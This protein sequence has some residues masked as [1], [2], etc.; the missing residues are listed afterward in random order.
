[1]KKILLLLT[2][3]IAI[4]VG[5]QKK[6]NFY[7][8]RWQP[9]ESIGR[10]RYLSII[11]KNDSLWKRTDYFIKENK[12]QMVGTYKDSETKTEHGP[13]EYF[14]ANGI[15]QSKGSYADGKKE[16]MWLR[17]YNNGAIQDS[18]VYTNGEIKGIGLAWHRNGFLADSSTYNA[19]GSGISVQWHDNGNPSAA[20]MYTAARKQHGKW[21][22]FHKNGNLSCIEIY[23]SGQFVSK[24]YYFEDGTEMKDTASKDKE[25]SFPGGQKAWLRYLERNLYFPSQWKINGSDEIVVTVDW[26]IDEEG[27]IQ[28]VFV[29]SPF[30]PDFDKIAADV[31]RKSPKWLPALSHNRTIKAYR[32][33]PVT[34]AQL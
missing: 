16:G 5:A 21:Q 23:H 15:P 28:D 32:R 8:F 24:K 10:A 11:N 9:T 26:T 1:M 19:D 2:C 18:L 12:I 4:E 13:F 3:F 17:Y 14:H 27:N 34:F 22:Y 7:D 29:S 30:H 31:I 25:A 20:G 33:Q 6:E